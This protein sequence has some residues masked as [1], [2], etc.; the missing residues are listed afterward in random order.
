MRTE[1]DLRDAERFAVAAKETTTSDHTHSYAEGV[2]DALAWALGE[3]DEISGIDYQT[4]P[5][6]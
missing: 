1:D 2:Q 4:D 5:A 6:S 3:E